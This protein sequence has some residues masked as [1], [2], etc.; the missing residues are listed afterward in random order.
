MR[1]VRGYITIE[2]GLCMRTRHAF[3]KIYA[4]ATATFLRALGLRASRGITLMSPSIFLF[5]RECEIPHS[6]AKVYKN[7][8]KTIVLHTKCFNAFLIKF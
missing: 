1:D 8:D 3:I 4:V 5:V 2:E 7:I 6:T